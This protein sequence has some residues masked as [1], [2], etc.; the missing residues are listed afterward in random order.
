MNPYFSNNNCSV[1]KFWGAARGAISCVPRA[2]PHPVG[3]SADW[4]RAETHGSFSAGHQVQRQARLQTS[5]LRAGHQATQSFIGLSLSLWR[6]TGM[7][8]VAAARR[9]PH[10]AT[11]T[12]RPSVPTAHCSPTFPRLQQSLLRQ[13]FLLD[14]V[15]KG[16]DL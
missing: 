7:H 14:L 5:E 6:N 3:Q 13:D 2:V 15:L 10:A 11:S 12:P 8:C 4:C 16:E 1:M 9:K